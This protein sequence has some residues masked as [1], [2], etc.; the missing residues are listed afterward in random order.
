MSTLPVTAGDTDPRRR[1]SAPTPRVALLLFT[2]VVVGVLLFL[3]RSALTPFIVGALLIYILD[4]AVDFLARRRLGGRHI[5]RGLAV[6][7]VYALTFFLVVEGLALLLSPLIS[8]VLEYIRNLPQLLA[9]LDD[10]MEQVRRTYTTLDLPAPVRDFIDG[11]LDDLGQGAGQFDVGALLPI[12]RTLLGTVAAFFGFLI[13]PVWAFYILRDRVRLA[14]EFDSA[15][16]PAWRRDVRAVVNIIERVFGRWI[17]AQILLGLI[18]GAATYVGLLALGWLVD[19]RFLQFAVLLAVIAGLFELLPIIGPIIS[20]IPTLLVALTTADPVVALLGV[21][22]LYLAVQQLENAVLVPKIQGE[23]VELH[24]SIVIF[25][26]ILGAAIAG[27]PGAIFSVPVTAAG[28]NV[29]RYLFRRLSE[30]DP[31]IPP[32]D[33]PDMLRFIERPEP[34]GTRTSPSTDDTQPSA[35]GDE[36]SSAPERNAEAGDGSETPAAR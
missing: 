34:D 6:L 28:R 8:Q 31:A 7:L 3:G 4:P 17:R 30:D 10:V 26:L 25:V 36:Q 18:V 33:A 12:A 23:A 19:P 24:P 32:A 20:M 29:Y 35:T 14:H 11:L 15:I 16:P 2:V 1:L 5:P 27:L 22:V 21:I 13:I 9:A